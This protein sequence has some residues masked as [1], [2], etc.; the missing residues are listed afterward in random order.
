LS[1]LRIPLRVG[2]IV[3]ATVKRKVTNERVL[4][5]LK[6]H[7]LVAEPEQDVMPG[8]EIKVQVLAVFPRIRLRLL[9]SPPLGGR[10]TQPPLDLHT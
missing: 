1:I 7:V 5:S 6:G 2:E 10:S 8:D 4:I 9:P 3:S